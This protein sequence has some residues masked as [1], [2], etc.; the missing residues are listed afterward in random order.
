V[1]AVALGSI[2]L[3]WRGVLASWLML[4]P[5]AAVTFKRFAYYAFAGLL[6]G[7]VF[8][9]KYLYHVVAKG[10]WNEDRRLWRIM[11]PWL[12]LSLAFAIG[13]LVEAGLLSISTSY[14]SG[15]AARSL[16]FGFLIGYFSDS[17]LAKMQE[18]AVVLFGTPRRDK[19][20]S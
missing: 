1:L 16:G 18:I 11:S 9:V 13:A 3:T 2:F 5:D 8:G 14:P 4:E 6:G 7:T 19:E 17:A 10:L 15:R 20:P 12:S